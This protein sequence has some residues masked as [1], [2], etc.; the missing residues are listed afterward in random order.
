MFLSHYNQPKKISKIP[1]FIFAFYMIVIFIIENFYREY[2]KEQTE[3]LIISFQKNQNNDAFYATA[4]VFSELGSVPYAIIVLIFYNWCNIY[5]TFTLLSSLFLSSLFVGTLKMIYRGAR[6]Y[7]DNPDIYPHD[8]EAGWGNPS[9]HSL[10]AVAFYLTMW[11]TAFQNSKLNKMFVCKYLALLFLVML[12]LLIGAARVVLAAHS[13]NQVIFGYQIGFG[14]FYLLFYVIKID[15][16]NESQFLFFM[17]TRNLIYSFLNVL[18]IIIGLMLFYFSVDV[19]KENDYNSIISQQFQKA[20]K[21]APCEARRLQKDGLLSLAIFFANYSAFLGIKFEMFFVFK[22][23]IHN[24]KSYNFNIKFQSDDESVLTSLSPINNVTQWNHTSSFYSIFRL[25][26]IIIVVLLINYPFYFISW[27]ADFYIII[28]FK[29]LFP[30]GN[31][32]FVMFFL[33]KIL[34]K[35]LRL[36]NNSLYSRMIDNLDNPF[37]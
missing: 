37:A 19:E 23:D 34:L 9:G 18:I 35:F 13:I 32:C 1:Y 36:T 17:N 10:Y 14:I 30:I 6:P 4:Q 5:K 8:N 16:T 7:F 3:N 21:T 24:W 12:I 31:T 15:T 11:K 29:I 20:N 25:I 28:I 22:G 27:N 2:L 26:I 33:L